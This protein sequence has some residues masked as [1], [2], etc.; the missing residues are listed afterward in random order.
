MYKRPSLAIIIVNWNAGQQLRECLESLI[1][2]SWDRFE[3][4]LVV[5]VDNASCDGSVEGLASLGLPIIIIR[6]T[7]N[8]GFAAAC[9]QGAR[10]SKANY[11]LFL[12]PDTRLFENSLA[13]PLS[14]MERPNN[15]HIGIVGIQLVD[16]NGDVSRTCSR[17]PTPGQFFS[18]MLGLDR[19]FP[20]FFP[21][22]FMFEWDHADSR[23]VEQVMG[24]F[25]LVRR[26][27]FETLGGFDE[28]FFVYFEEVD[29]SL[30]SRQAG[31]NSF[32]L[33]E[34]Q[35]Y[36]KGGGT[37]EKVKALRLFYSLRSR[38]L[39][40]YKHF[41][42]VAAT[43]LMLGTLFLEPWTRLALG[44]VRRSG[45]E[46]IETLKGYYMLWVAVPV[47]L[48]TAWQRGKA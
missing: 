44:L 47:L 32:Y 12:N 23:Y 37:S 15:Q 6:N 20:S 45:K 38:I 40:S 9:N 35:A 46:I 10:G 17:F 39:Y 48:K 2:A 36:H 4:S 42:W 21:S 11:L 25:F 3:L 28:R 19:L 31:W 5:V 41:G 13:K 34:A 26:S 29:F 7:E 18:K 24:A 1:T 22:H 16:G 43:G 33:A 30:R 27:L 14:F 8:R